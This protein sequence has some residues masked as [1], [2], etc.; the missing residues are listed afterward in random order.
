MNTKAG[1][2]SATPGSLELLGLGY[3]WGLKKQKKKGQEGNRNQKNLNRQPDWEELGLIVV[4]ST[5]AS[6]SPVWIS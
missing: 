5:G 1:A 3:N 6:S 2:V 4:A